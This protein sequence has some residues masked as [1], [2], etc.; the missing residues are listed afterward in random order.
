[1]V[2]H[3]EDAIGIAIDEVDNSDLDSL[4][5]VDSATRLVRQM[6]Q[7]AFRQLLVREVGSSTDA[8]AIAL[9]ARRLCER[10]A[11]QLT[12][13]IGDAG[14]S[15]ICSRSLHLAQRQFPSLVSVPAQVDGAFA[16][17]QESLQG[18][19][20]AVASDAAVAV[21]TTVSNLLDSLIGEGL[22]TRLLRG[23]WP[24]SFDVD[25]QETV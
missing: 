23:A 2:D 3:R 21:L 5:S 22:T 24:G 6:R 4:S 9:A 25:T 13:I 17:V 20:P 10:F 18:L 12:P 14:V 7:Q 1:V 8:P 16:R 19:E 15:A 11:Q